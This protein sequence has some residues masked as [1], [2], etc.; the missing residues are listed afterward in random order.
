MPTK[1]VVKLSHYLRD[2]D[3]SIAFAESATTGRLIYEFTSVPDCGKTV[4]GSIVCYDPSVKESLLG[5]PKKVLEDCTPESAEV[6]RYLAESLKKLIPADIIVAVTGLASPGG[7]ETPEKPVGTMF[8][9][10]FIHDEPF[11]RRMYF[12]GEPDDI[13]KQTIEQVAV[14]LLEKIA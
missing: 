12:E 13:I 5:V 10:G 14:L 3:L 6:T 8:V 9:E 2:H 7:S 11:G 4:R 1:S